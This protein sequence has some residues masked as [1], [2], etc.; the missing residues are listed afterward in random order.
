MEYW[1]TWSLSEAKETNKNEGKIINSINIA[2]QKT[3]MKY[4][5]K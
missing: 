3:I 1:R 5:I 2:K 4:E